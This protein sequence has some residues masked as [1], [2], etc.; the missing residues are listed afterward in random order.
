[1]ADRCR[2]LIRGKPIFSHLPPPGVSGPW[3]LVP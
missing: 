1:L 2:G 3:S